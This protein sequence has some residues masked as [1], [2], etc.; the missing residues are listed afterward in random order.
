MSSRFDQ[1][2][3]QLPSTLGKELDKIIVQDGFSASLTAEQVKHLRQTTQLSE[4]ALI[5]ALLPIAAAYA[6]TPISHFP[7]GAIAK[8]QSGHLYFG[9]NMEFLH[10]P[11]QQTI[12]AEQCAITHAWLN[13]EERLLSLTI[14]HPPCG[15]CRQFIN[16]LNS[17]HE[18]Q[19]NLP[20]R[21]SRPFH[22]YLPD[23]F[24]PEALHIST[25]LMDRKQHLLTLSNDD[26][27][28]LAALDAANHSY[29]PYSQAHSGV[30]LQTHSGRVYTGR[31]AENA[32][33]NPS[34]PPLQAALVMLNMAGEALFSVYRAILV[35]SAA[36]PFSQREN[37]QNL[38]HKLECHHL[39]HYY[40]V[41]QKQ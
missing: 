27:L 31:Y 2:I 26:T 37:I 18:L 22:H 11:L 25:R 40:A 10:V 7:V 6:W 21:S 9:A 15:H 29:A 3:A 16:E 34:L 39:E 19:I 17:S 1:V 38:L 8:G 20:N 12:H 36:A 30:A 32:A 41:M 5:F 14:N 4:Q 35:E 13:G 23:D 24:G 28:V 33:F